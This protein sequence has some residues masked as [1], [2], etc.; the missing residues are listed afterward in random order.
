[1]YRQKLNHIKGITSP[2]DENMANPIKA[3]AE[4]RISAGNFTCSKLFAVEQIRS[5]VRRGCKLLRVQ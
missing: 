2:H 4:F 5:A 3:V 1:M